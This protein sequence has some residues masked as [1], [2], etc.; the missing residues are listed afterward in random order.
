MFVITADQADSR[1]TVDLVPATLT[2]LKRIGGRRLRRAPARTIGDEL[3]VL[4][5]DPGCALDLVLWL[6]RDGRWSTGCG[7][8]RFA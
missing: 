8:P 4:T 3:Q 5:A 2:Q 6:D 1:H 7:I